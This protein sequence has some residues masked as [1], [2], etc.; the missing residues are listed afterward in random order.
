MLSYI[1]IFALCVAST[2][3]DPI[4]SIPDGQVRGLELQTSSNKSFYGFQGIPYGLPPVGDLRFQAPL[5]AEPW[6]G[7]LNATHEAS[8]C[9]FL[10]NYSY[11]PDPLVENEDCLFINVY[12][13]TLDSSSKLSVMFWIYGGGYVGGSGEYRYY[14]AD[15]L[16]EDDVVV[17]TFNYRLGP[18]G[19]LSTGDEVIP[20]N[21]AMKDQ[22]L[23][24]QWVKKNIEYFGGDPDKVTIFGESSGGMSV[25][26]HLISKQSAGL[27]R[28]AICQSSCTIVLG[29]QLDPKAL[30][31]SVAQVL[32]ESITRQNTSQEL[33]EL[34]LRTPADVLNN[35]CTQ[36]DTHLFRP[37]LEVD[38]EGA[39]MTEPL[40]GLIESGNINKVPLIIGTC[41]EEA[42]GFLKTLDKLT[43]TANTWDTDVESLIPEDLIPLPGSNL[44]EIGQSIKELYVGKG[45]SFSTQ[46]AQ[47]LAYDTDNIFLRGTIKQ[48]QLQSKYA[49]VYLYKFSFNGTKSQDHYHVE[50]AGYVG[51]FDE[52]PYIFKMEPF[53]LVTEADDLARRITT[54]LWTNFA[55]TLNPTPTPEETEL[56]QNVTWPLATPEN[57][58]YL[59]IDTAL[60]VR[61]DAKSDRWAGWDYI[62]YKYGTQP[63]MSF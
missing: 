41:E 20:G 39:F 21:A 36:V 51:H 8:P 62:F 34:L 22:V 45:G 30:I 3:G 29:Y 60:E 35:A 5:P 7:I 24:L 57:L 13:P 38:S 25:G 42:L 58:Q 52:L 19:F 61:R 15:Y 23:A 12:T 47:A 9:I 49:P 46:L 43:A 33:K 31:Y 48:V 18:F 11:Y 40:F 28:A 16:V 6:S 44:T 1:A 27:F 63:F 17:V 55:K 32:D 54:K 2:L 37:V 4:V 10:V 53:P 14:G 56:L 50:G 26:L 59:N